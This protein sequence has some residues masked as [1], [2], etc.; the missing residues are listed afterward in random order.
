M[1]IAILSSNKKPIPSPP[2][3]I[4]APGII[5]SAIADDMVKKGH[6]VT[7]FAG[8][9]SRTKAKL[10]SVGNTQFT[11]YGKIGEPLESQYELML[12]AK[13]FEVAQKGNFDLIHAHD[14][15][16]TIYFSKLIS[17][18]IL[19]TYHGN[20]SE[21]MLELIEK[22]RAIYFKDSIYSVGVTDYQI[23]NSKNL[24]NFVGRVYHGIDLGNF[25]FSLLDGQLLPLQHHVLHSIDTFLSHHQLLFLYNL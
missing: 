22:Q 21:D 11:D 4:Y 15:R 14:Y 7:L 24:I 3:A 2:D 5:I 9:E 8:K 6:E 25:E 10:V 18:P 20:V 13:C 1:R 16:K 17:T 19:F 12:T 23:K